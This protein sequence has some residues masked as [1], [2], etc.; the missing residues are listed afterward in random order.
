[1]NKKILVFSLIAALSLS[2]PFTAMAQP[3]A[4]ATYSSQTLLSAVL[5]TGAGAAKQPGFAYKNHTWN[6]VLSGSPTTVS[7]TLEGS[8]DG[9]TWFVLDTGTSTTNEMRHVTNKPVLHLRANVGTLSGGS[10]PSV[11]VYS[12]S[13]AF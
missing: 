9:V 12:L 4:Y 6:T 5:V 13:V 11:T 3:T 10:T 7:V 2:F 1:M 8:L